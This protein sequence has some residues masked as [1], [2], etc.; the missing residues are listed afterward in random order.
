MLPWVMRHLVGTK[1][2]RDV[3]RLRPLV[4]QINQQEIGYQALT[5]MAR[6]I[7]EPAW[8]QSFLENVPDNRELL[9]MWERTHRQSEK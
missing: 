6:K 8:R 1:N 9:E 5:E 4:D 3:R 7:S 2:Q